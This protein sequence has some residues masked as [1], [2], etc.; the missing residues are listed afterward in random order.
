MLS[1]I[2]AIFF[3]LLNGIRAIAYTLVFAMHSLKMVEWG[4]FVGCTPQTPPI[5]T[6]WVGE[7]HEH[8]IALTIKVSGNLLGFKVFSFRG[9][10]CAHPI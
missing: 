8:A 6:L 2:L 3:F 4:V 9:F 7:M 1:H 10:V 5:F